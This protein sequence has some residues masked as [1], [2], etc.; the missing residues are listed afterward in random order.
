MLVCA[1]VYVVVESKETAL[2]VLGVVIALFD[3]ATLFAVA[4]LLRRVG[5]N[6]WPVAFAMLIPFCFLTYVGTE[7]ALSGVCLA[8]MMLAAWKV[9]VRP[10]GRAAGL[11]TLCY[12]LAVLSRL[13][14]IFVVSC[15]F[16]GVWMALGRMGSGRRFLVAALPIPLIFWGGYVGSNWVYFHTIEPISGMLKSHGQAH[17]LGSNLPHTGVVP[18]IVITLCLPLMALRQRD[19]FFR[20]V[21]LPMAVGVYVHACYIV[22]LMSSET[23]WPWYYTSWIL[24]ASILLARVSALVLRDRR[25]VAVGIS[26]ACFIF[27]CALWYKL[28]YLHYYKMPRLFDIGNFNKVAAREGIKT[29]IVYDKPGALA[30]YSTVKIVPMDGLMG[31]LN[32]QH[33][34]ATAGIGDFIVKNDIDAFAGPPTS[35]GSGTEAEECGV[36]LLYAVRFHCSGK[37]GEGGVRIDSVD[38]FARLPP[39][40]AGTIPLPQAEAISSDYATMWRLDTYKRAHG[41]AKSTPR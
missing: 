17:S 1:L 30:Y 10:S 32:F 25:S 6:M 16:V 33:E 20:A 4:A 3:V 24:L 36:M 19:L 7:G 34:L 29:L 14:N 35:G 11:Y 28:D 22:F 2:H 12:T 40:F 9:C 26:A 27:L 18:L 5:K 13:D 23:R 8:L 15:V 37:D 38:I 21:E 31:D 41:A 39:T